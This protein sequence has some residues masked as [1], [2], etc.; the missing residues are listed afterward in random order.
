[1][2]APLLVGGRAQQLALTVWEHI[3]IVG[4]REPKARGAAA[5]FFGDRRWNKRPV[6]RQARYDAVAATTGRDG[7]LCLW[8]SWALGRGPP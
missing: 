6:G 2:S 3:P 7:R 1:L 8:E 5:S 4:R